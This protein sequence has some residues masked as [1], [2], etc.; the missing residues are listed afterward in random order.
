MS[1]RR[2]QWHDMNRVLGVELPL[3]SPR[4][5]G[6]GLTGMASVSFQQP[7]RRGIATTWV[8]KNKWSSHISS[9]ANVPCW[10]LA[11]LVVIAMAGKRLA[12]Q[13]HPKPQVGKL[14]G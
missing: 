8:V 4:D 10:R 12:C 9:T 1:L 11:V 7:V 3:L 5:D 13:D 6:E 14:D 2:T